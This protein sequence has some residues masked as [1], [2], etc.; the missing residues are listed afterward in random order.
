MQFCPQ[1]VQRPLEPL[2]TA[3]PTERHLLFS[4]DP[5]FVIP[6]IAHNWIRH[7]NDSIDLPGIH[8]EFL[9]VHRL[10][11]RTPIHK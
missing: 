7:L 3:M 8:H 1:A 6:L 4:F 5:K 10:R 9:F 2:L 11:F